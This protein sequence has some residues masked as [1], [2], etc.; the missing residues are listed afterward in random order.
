MLT[1]ART[2]WTVARYELS[3]S[4]RSRR[5]I[6]LLFLY[7]AGSI[8][9]TAGFIHV[10]QRIEVQLVA[11][12]GLASAGQTGSVTA[13]LWKSDAFRQMLIDL[14]G[15]RALAE[16][17]LAIPPLA[18]Y[19]GWLSFMFTP[20]L[21]VLT[22]SA[23][24]SEEIAS[25]SVRFVLFRASRLDWCMGKFAGQAAQL[26][27]ALL[28][29]AIG[30]WCVGRLRMHFFE[31][32]ATADAMLIF[33]AKAWVYSLAFLGLATAISQ[34]C[35]SPNLA[36]AL[37]FLALLGLSA[38]AAISNHFAGDGVRRLWDV[39]NA[40]TPQAHRLDLWWGDAAHA[41]PAVVFLVALAAV[42]ML[43]GHARFARRDV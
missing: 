32:W 20:F 43:A 18:L 9:A 3:D 13:T 1:P 14:I 11:S 15:D 2:I 28:L 36:V 29:S 8:A 38:L 40:L 21:I 10:L 41:L 7:L 37:G 35:A 34:L 6:V 24:V 31:P 42:Y 19:Y 39:V 23:R 12:L 25:G 22:S 27:L 5:V 16:S 33:A 17:L 30:A 4:V 26:A